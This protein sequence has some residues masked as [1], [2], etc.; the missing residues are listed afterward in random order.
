MFHSFFPSSHHSI[1]H[2]GGDG[3]RGVTLD[4]V[5]FEDGIE[6]LLGD[7]FGAAAVGWGGRGAVVEA[8]RNRLNGVV[9]G[10]DDDVVEVKE[11]GFSETDERSSSRVWSRDDADDDRHHD[12]DFGSPVR[13][14]KKQSMTVGRRKKTAKSPVDEEEDEERDDS[15][16]RSGDE[17][18]AAFSNDHVE[19]EDSERGRH[20]ASPN[21][22]SSP[23]RSK[24]KSL[25]PKTAFCTICHKYFSSKNYLAK[26][27]L[28]VHN[29]E[30]FPSESLA[31]NDGFPVKG[32]DHNDG[33]GGEEDDDAKATNG[34]SRDNGATE[35][36]S[37]CRDCGVT[38]PSMFLLKRHR[39]IAHGV[40]GGGTAMKRKKPKLSTSTSS[41]AV[42]INKDHLR[43]WEPKCAGQRAFSSKSK[44]RKHQQTIHGIEA[45]WNCT[46]CDAEFKTRQG[47]QEHVKSTHEGVKI[48]CLHC[49]KVGRAV[50]VKDR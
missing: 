13:K 31:E 34:S 25:A 35:E 9:I 11:E 48:K 5:K 2:A 23:H 10:D 8:G 46:E 42:V 45:K 49:D 41:S 33:G 37:A 6:D 22:L 15:L 19:D 20:Q 18:D 26:H 12:D 3:F 29:V 28:N 7:R 27:A 50:V 30:L 44:L 4:D 40:G 21:H 36:P 39:R 38:Y 43:C 1:I 47:C 14:R 16:S 32:E 17:D 24:P